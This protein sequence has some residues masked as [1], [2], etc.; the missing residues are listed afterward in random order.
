MRRGERTVDRSRRGLSRLTSRGRDP[1]VIGGRDISI[2]YLAGNAD[3]LQ[4]CLLPG[5]HV[6]N[7]KV[8]V[9][10]NLLQALQK[11]L[12]A[13][14]FLCPECEVLSA[15]LVGDHGNPTLAELRLP[16]VAAQPTDSRRINRVNNNA[17]LL[18]QFARGVRVHG[19]GGRNGYTDAP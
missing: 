19:N 5:W 18:T 9:R 1:H 14:G 13:D 12:E 10:E 3:P 7:Q 16:G 4:P 17:V 6:Q 2:R 15:G 8:L 11:R